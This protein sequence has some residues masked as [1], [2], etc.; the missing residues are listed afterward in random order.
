[1]KWRNMSSIN[2]HT[3][4]CNRECVMTWVVVNVVGCIG[5]ADNIVGGKGVLIGMLFV[6]DGSNS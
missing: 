4:V 1:M 5:R 6:K 2:W 3:H